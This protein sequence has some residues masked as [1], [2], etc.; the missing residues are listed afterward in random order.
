[1]LTEDYGA[2]LDQI[3]RFKKLFPRGAVLNARNAEKAVKHNIWID[4]LFLKILGDEDR[5]LLGQY[6][7]DTNEIRQACSYPLHMDSGGGGV[8][9]RADTFRRKFHR[10]TIP[11]FFK[12]YR[13]HA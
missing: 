3:D 12:H 8:G 11:I 4:W 1:M 10:K 2:C 13:E 5:I 7:D 9:M 6:S